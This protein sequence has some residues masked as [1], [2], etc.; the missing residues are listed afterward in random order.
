MKIVWNQKAHPTNDHKGNDDYFKWVKDP[1]L[2]LLYYHLRDTPK[3]YNTY[4][5]KLPL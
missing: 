5:A 1:V 2:E 3:I 4:R